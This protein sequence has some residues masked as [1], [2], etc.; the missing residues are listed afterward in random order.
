MPI[1]NNLIQKIEKEGIL[2]NLYYEIS[3]T[4]ISKLKTLQEN[5]RPIFFMKR[6]VKN[7]RKL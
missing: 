4:L 6:D 7:I 5:C 3:I 2:H 1:L